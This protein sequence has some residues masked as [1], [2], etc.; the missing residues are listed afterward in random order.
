MPQKRKYTAAQKRAF[1]ARMARARAASSRSTKTVSGRGFYKGFSRDAGAFLGRA[2]GGRYGLGAPGAAIGG[3]LGQ[4]FADITGFGSYNIPFSLTRNT[5]ALPNNPRI[6]NDLEREGAVVISHR[7]HI[8]TVKSSTAFQIQ[9]E[10]P[11]NPA[12]EA[13][14]P[15]LSSTSSNFTQYEMLGCI[16]EYVSTSGDAV[17]STN[18]ALGEVIMTSNANSL[19]TSYVNKT[20]M[21]NSDFCQAFSP[22]RNGALPIECAPQQSTLTKLYTRYGA[23]KPGADL[24]MSDLGVVT[25]ATSGMQAA[26]IEIGE[27]YVNYQ[28]ALFKPQLVEE[29]GFTQPMA[30]Y[31]LAGVTGLVPLGT[32]SGRTSIID[33]IGCTFN[34]TTLIIP[35]NTSG[36]WQMDYV[37]Q[38]SSVLTVRP[39][40]T[41]VNA[42]PINATRNGTQPFIDDAGNTSDTYML[43]YT[44]EITDPTDEARVV[45]SSTG[46]LPTTPSTSDIRLTQLNWDVAP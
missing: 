43:T 46:T 41:L 39:L 37:V 38:G 27:L 15:W 28:V 9:Y 31:E 6:K 8:G 44:F 16:F 4:K 12:Q 25:I 3:H 45:F 22:S 36:R 35:R 32:S 14:F 10:L 24:R 17:S 18:N 34:S 33:T 40:I 30:Y 20:Q 19:D 23:V 21:L 2:V 29:L 11:L 5:L 26:D 13:T 1:A 42:Q 7:E